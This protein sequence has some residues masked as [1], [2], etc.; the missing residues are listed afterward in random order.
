MRDFLFDTPYWLLGGLAVLG[1]A[2]WFS[3][4]A[5]QEKRL[6]L[7]GYFALLIAV[8]LGLLSY[9]V[10]TDRE[11]VIRRTRQIVQAVENKDAATAQQLLHPHASLGRS[12]EMNKQQIVDRIGTAA[13][14]FGI[15]SIRITSLVVTPQPLGQE[16]TV[17][18]AAT[19]NST[20]GGYSAPVPSTW[21]LNWVKT[22]DGWL[23]RDIIPQ[24]VPTMDPSS[25]VDRLKSFKPPG[26]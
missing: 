4:N 15:H 7:A 26:T 8:T 17:T 3:G 22:N 23:L 2:L 24:Q 14:Q 21:D 10:D 6:Q 16:M 19:A 25:L 13:D 18:L 20:F 9:F 5:R 12:A 11:I 1:I